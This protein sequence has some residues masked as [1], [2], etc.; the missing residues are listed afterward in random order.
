[1]ARSCIIEV[2]VKSKKDIETTLLNGRRGSFNLVHPQLRLLYLV[3]K[4]QMRDLLLSYRYREE[5]Q[6]VP[7]NSLLG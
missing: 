3:W 2:Q 6:Q 7:L 5:E 4:T 1:M